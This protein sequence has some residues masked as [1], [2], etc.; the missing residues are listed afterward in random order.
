[1][2]QCRFIDYNKCSTPVGDV[3]NG[4]LYPRE[5]GAGGIWE[6]SL[7]H[8]ILC[9]PKTAV[10]NKSLLKNYNSFNK[11]IQYCFIPEIVLGAKAVT[12][13]KTETLALLV[14]RVGVGKQILNITNN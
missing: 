1:M 11:V 3:D 8:S 6:L 10:K 9:K 2:S 4:G 5:G 14:F 13:D 12:V 7:L